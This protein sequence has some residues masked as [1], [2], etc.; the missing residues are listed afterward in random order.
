MIELRPD[1]AEGVS[2]FCWAVMVRE[3]E[4]AQMLTKAEER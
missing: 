2:L 3:A 4:A 1:E